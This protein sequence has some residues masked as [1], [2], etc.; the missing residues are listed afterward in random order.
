M[1]DSHSQGVQPSA[2]PAALAAGSLSVLGG[3]LLARP[4]GLGPV[5]DAFISLR[6]ALHWAQGQGLVF[7]PG[8]RVEGYTN[9]A[10][11]ALEAV[12]I[13][14]GISPEAAMLGLGWLSLFALAASVATFLARQ[15]RPGEVVFPALAATLV[16]LNPMVLAWSTSGLE[17]GLYACLIVTSILVS[18]RADTPRR[19]A[20][21][22]G[23]LALAALTRP[24]AVVLAPVLWATAV[25]H[26][27]RQVGVAFA[28]VFTAGVGIYFAVRGIYFD[29]WLPNTFYA[30]LDYGG[31]ALAQRGA[32]Y[33]MG[34]LW[35]VP[36]LTLATLWGILR[37]K[38][39]PGWA[40]PVLAVVIAQLAVIVW[41]GGDHFPLY[42]F[43][44][45]ILPLL[46]LLSVAVVSGNRW[47]SL[48]GL[49]V[50]AAA[51]P[52]VGI[53]RPWSGGEGELARFSREVRLARHWSDLGQYLARHA[54]PD[55]SLATIAIGA[56]GFHSNLRLV[57]P[58]GIVDPVIAQLDQ[59]LGQGYAGHEK[60]DVDD[61][62][63]RRPHYLLIF[64]LAAPGRLPEAVLPQ[65]VWGQ[66][67]RTLIGRPELA[68]DYR[69]ED[70]VVGDHWWSLHVRRD[71]PAPR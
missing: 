29:R 71:V 17:T 64:N 60:F 52:T 8:E 50:L 61:L 37:W 69:L 55:A 40:A 1:S 2:L 5:D 42:R 34:F 58:H 15:V 67:N 20:L 48:A 43:A 9:F 41:E 12:A 66:F 56:L 68:E 35:A 47:R 65:L 44:V 33:A 22:G 16:A 57:D 51:L 18:W 19:G 46:A 49:V 11:V 27:E 31:V 24:E 4:L 7:N 32:A 10:W 45:P 25:R 13:R 62:L 6:Y 36:S 23:C 21:A 39:A 63:S 3:A 30:K 26:R 59:P 38:R 14:C 53:A 28:A 54:Q 70:L